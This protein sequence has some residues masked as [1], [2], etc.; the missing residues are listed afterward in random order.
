MSG[1]IGGFQIPLPTLDGNNAGYQGAVVMTP[2]TFTYA[3]QRAIGFVCAA[4][5]TMTVTL[6]DASTMA[7]P[8]QA[9][10]SFQALPLAATSIVLSAGTA[11]TFWNLK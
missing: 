3:P 4:S 9:A 7:I 1:S 6:S 10:P 2:G 5:G 11:G 8:V